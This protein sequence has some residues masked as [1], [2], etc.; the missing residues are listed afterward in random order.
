MVSTTTKYLYNNVVYVIM[1]VI[2]VELEDDLVK[3][4]RMAVLSKHGTLK[5]HIKDELSIALELYLEKIP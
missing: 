2:N 1:S 4:F 3:R 5:N